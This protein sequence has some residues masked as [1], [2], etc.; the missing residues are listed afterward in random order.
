MVTEVIIMYREEGRQHPKNIILLLIFT[1]AQSYTVSFICS[2]VVAMDRGA[3]VL[4]AACMTFSTY[5][6]LYY[7]VVTICL[8]FYAILTPYNYTSTYAAIIALVVPF[9]LL[10]NFILI[11]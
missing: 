6:L 5:I 1:F 10:G 7:I 3:I 9:I 8:T 2:L 4:T 11:L